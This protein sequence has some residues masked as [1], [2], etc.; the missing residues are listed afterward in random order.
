MLLNAAKMIGAGCATA[1]L[2]GAGAGIGT[3]FGALVVGMSRNPSL[4]KEM[5]NLRHLYEVF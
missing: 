2:A 4:E 5:L 3:V 1:G